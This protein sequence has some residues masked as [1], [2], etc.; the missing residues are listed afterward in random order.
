MLKTMMLDDFKQK[1]KIA[2]KLKTIPHV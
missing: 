2:Y 1:K